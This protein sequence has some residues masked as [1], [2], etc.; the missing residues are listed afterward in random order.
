M[1]QKWQTI[2]IV[3]ILVFVIPGVVMTRISA[4][5]DNK[6]VNP[7]T[8][9]TDNTKKDEIT[10]GNGKEIIIDVLLNDG[11][12]EP[13]SLEEYVA[14]VV[15]AEMPVSFETEALKAQAVVARTYTLR[16]WEGLRKH[17]NANVCTKPSC[18]Q[19]YRSVSDYMFSGGKAEDIE[20]VKKAVECT[21]GLVLT[22]KGALIEATYFSCSGGVTEDALAVWGEEIPYLQST[23]SPGEEYADSFEETQSLD[24]H[25]VEKRL[26]VK[27][28]GD[29]KA[30]IGKSTYT[31]GLGV[32][33][34]QICD[35]V[36]SGTDIRSLLDLHSTAFTISVVGETVVISTKG[37][38][39]R[40]GMSQYGADAMAMKGNL[41]PDILKHYY[42]DTDVVVYN[43]YSKK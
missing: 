33:K 19:G 10:E 26:G 28:E 12:I 36:F 23:L 21:T 41:Y 5:T 11:S 3:F 15:L 7:T 13:I 16:R 27:F 8:S 37:Y 24:L 9:A 30:W 39:H 34:I 14:G 1:Y 25:D 29:P 4:G 22:Y 20:K 31:A 40:V 18:C 35:K 38:G 42:K 32:N 6:P 2:L 17:Q 43:Y